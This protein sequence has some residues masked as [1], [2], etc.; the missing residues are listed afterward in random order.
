M[1]KIIRTTDLDYRI[2]TGQNGVITL[3]TTNATGD[4]SGKVVVKG[5]LELKGNTTEVSSTITTIDDNIIVLSAN[6]DQPGLPA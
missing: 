5:D 6:N 1:S 4:G 3:D 2:I